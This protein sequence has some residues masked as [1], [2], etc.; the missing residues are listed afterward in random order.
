MGKTKWGIGGNEIHSDN[1]FMIK[2]LKMSQLITYY[3]SGV[4]QIPNFQRE[5]DIDKVK[6]IYKNHK[7]KKKIGENWILQQGILT[8]CVIELNN[9]DYKLYLIDGQHRLFAIE[10]LIRKNVIADDEIMIQMKKCSSIKEMKRYF[11]TLNINSNIEIQYQNLEQEFYNSLINNFKLKIKSLFPN[12]FSRSKKNTKTNQFLHID[13][14]IELFSLNKMKKTEFVIN[15]KGEDN[16]LNLELLLERLVQ[17]NMEVKDKY[18]QIRLKDDITN[19]LYKVAQKKLE[20]SGLY[21]AL[22]N[23]DWFDYLIGKKKELKIK[24]QKRKK[25]NIPKK[26]RIKVWEKRFGDMGK[27]NCFCCQSELDK[28][29][30]HTGHIVSEFEGGKIEVNNLEPI[31]G[32]CNSS[33]GII[34]MNEFIDKYY[35]KEESLL[36]IL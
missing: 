29:D 14:F 3:N 17:I 32:S 20:K 35:P 10:N 23:V 6:Q 30:F 33:M 16:K 28:T 15:K 25:E 4:I 9:K 36:N 21:L 18:D 19:Y 7:K 34:N 31:C 22:K 11:K 1:V 5:I 8:I 27:G 2:K 13:Q 24:P 26:I 12:A